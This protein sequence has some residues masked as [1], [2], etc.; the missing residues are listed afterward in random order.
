MSDKALE[1]FRHV[2][3]SLQAI[4]ARGEPDNE[5]RPGG[6]FDFT[7]QFSFLTDVPLTEFCCETIK[8]TLLYPRERADK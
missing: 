3:E 4:V 2:N 7:P 1:H 8:W 6:R 5:Q